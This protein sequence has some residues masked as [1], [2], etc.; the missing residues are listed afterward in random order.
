MTSV[1]PT[2]DDL[3]REPELPQELH[4]LWK[5]R[6]AAVLLVL[7]AFGVVLAGV[8]SPRFDLDRYLV[9]K[10]LVL[11]LVALGMLLLGFPSLRAA[12]WG[13]AEWLFVAFVASSGVSTALAT[14]RWLALS[15]W[16]IG[17][18]SLV[19]L[20]AARE[21]AQTHR[22][23]VL[24]GV[25]AAAVVG[26]GF[27]IA[28][29]YGASWELLAETRPPGGTFG[30]RNFL[31]H[32]S[33]LAA[34]PLAM[35]VA[36]ANRPRWLVPA[37]VGLGV[38]TAAVVLTRSRAA[39]LG[40]IG[41]GVSAAVAL[42]ISR[43]GAR[44]TRRRTVALVAA[45]G[46][47]S[48]AAVFLPNRLQWTSDSPYAE[49]LTR[50]VESGQ[51]S[52]RGRLI[53]YRN[54]LELAKEA[55]VW[56]VGPGNWFVHYPR[57]TTDGDPAYAGHLSIPTNPWPSSDWVAML[58]ERGV[59]GVLLFLVAGGLAAGRA[60]AYARTGS[61]DEALAGAALVALIVTAFVTGS[62]DAVLLLAAPSYLVWTATG[63]L[64]PEPRR[65]TEWIPPA[66][67]KRVR[68]ICALIVLM[69]V[70][71]S[72]THTAAI[73]MT[74]TGRSRATLQKAARVY[75]GEHRLQILLA[76]RGSCPAARQARDLMPHHANV[77]RMAAS[78]GR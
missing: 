8:E 16:G 32:M 61:R 67:R 5:T 23:Q 41:G 3:L 46:V 29:A 10:A 31:A 12:R 27:G 65:P 51:G 64:L 19:L 30:N 39:W 47:A 18:S 71:D 62:F 40:G 58:S 73:M 68:A 36:R 78:C 33:V 25:V 21:V 28:Q 17:V 60:L 49:T 11:H 44:P 35:L 24:A 70:A 50:L 63:L 42:L 4:P 2:L 34:P 15:A 55:P 75:P 37:L 1:V 9:P 56:G 14:N 59:L 69:L 72:A 66:P 53:Q 7:G 52:G 74:G 77:K 76:E 48:A 57:V 22:W 38:V 54:S 13:Y 43:G 6:A 20:L 26:A 45:L